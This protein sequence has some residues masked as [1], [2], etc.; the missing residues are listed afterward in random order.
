MKIFIYLLFPLA[1]LLPACSGQEKEAMAKLENA[2]S[3]YER[4]EWMAAKSEIDSIRAWYPTQTNVLR[5]A[6]SLMRLIELGEAERN[7]I[8]CD[9]LL[10]IRQAELRE[11]SRGFVFEQDTAYEASGNYIHPRLTIERN[12]E[13]SYLRCGVNGEGELYLTSVY[14][15]TRP[16]NHTGIRLT[17]QE[18]LFA[19]TPAVPHD[20]GLNYR[21]NDG[22]NLSE[23]VTYKGDDGLEAIRFIQANARDKARLKIDYTGGTSF[24]L[25]LEEADKKAIAETCDLASVLRDLH[26]LNTE[27]EKATKKKDYLTGKLNQ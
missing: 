25:Y 8:Y 2:R 19:E 16:L 13:R 24:S 1:V 23:I 9:S 6:L 5:D 22:G 11:A 20:G 27:R 18:G 26:H 14:F 10:P 12:V 4:S 21:F 3:L 17:T 15:G 7:I